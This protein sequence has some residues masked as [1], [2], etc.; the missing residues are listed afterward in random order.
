MKQRYRMNPCDCVFHGLDYYMRRRGFPGT[1]TFMVIDADGPLEP[2]RVRRALQRAMEAHPMAMGRAGVS[3]WR[4]LPVWEWDGLPVGPQ[5][6]HTDLSK[7][8]DWTRVADERFHAGL[9]RSPDSTTPPQ[10]RL[11]HYQGPQ[12]HQRLYFCWPHALMD[13]EGAQHFLAEINRLSTDPPSAAPATRVPDDRPI[14]VLA[15]AG[16]LRRIRL[17]L[18]GV[19][20]RSPRVRAQEYSLCGA[21]PECRTDSRNYCHIVRRWPAE[22]VAVMQAVARQ[23]APAGPALYTRHLAASVL[24]AVQRIHLEH[25]RRPARYDILL[26]MRLP[27]LTRRPLWGNYLVAASIV[28][29]PEALDDRRALAAQ[30]AAGY[31]RYM[32]REGPLASWALQRITAQLRLSQY[33]RL[34]DWQTVAQPFL[35]GFSVYGEIDPPLREFVGARVT[36]LYGAAVISTPPGWNVAISRFGEH[37]NLSIAWPEAAFPRAVVERYAALIEEEAGTAPD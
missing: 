13:A 28:V 21:L 2:A 7:V 17:S 12:A 25:G 23:T 27:G 19:G 8:A 24:R 29:A 16:I 18:G 4:A 33:R 30:L 32:A 14:D 9:A 1:A 6:T 5:Y 35:T 20:E 34:I 10:V 15:R 31:E 26:P 3:R 36:N 37:A 11:E 22:R